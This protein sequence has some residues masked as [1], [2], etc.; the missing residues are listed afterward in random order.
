M[1]LNDP[2]NFGC[3]LRNGLYKILPAC[4]NKLSVLS[5]RLDAIEIPREYWGQILEMSNYRQYERISDPIEQLLERKVHQGIIE[6][7][8]KDEL[9][10]NYKTTLNQYES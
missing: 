9:T 1:L 4:G 2:H 6:E 3:I 8:L 10:L 5:K 7:L